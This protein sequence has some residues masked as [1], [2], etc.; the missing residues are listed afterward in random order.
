MKL[1]NKL[2]QHKPKEVYALVATLYFFLFLNIFGS[3]SRLVKLNHSVIVRL[4]DSFR[5]SRLDEILLYFTL[6]IIFVVIGI[7]NSKTKKGYILVTTLFVLLFL[8]ISGY[9]SHVFLI[10]RSVIYGLIRG[11]GELSTYPALILY[12][13]LAVIF[14]GIG[15]LKAKKISDWLW[16]ND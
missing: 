14:V 12:W 9:I 13:V 11:L 7:K 2:K 1:L 10:R 15:I 3:L 16:D 5:L 4:L 6:A 8:N